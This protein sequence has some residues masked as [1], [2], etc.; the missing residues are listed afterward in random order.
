MALTTL[1]LV[2]HGATA[3]NVRE[4]QCLQGRWQDSE[5]IEAGH[6]QAQ[7]TGA[8][9]RGLSLSAIYSSPLMRA[10]QTAEHI[11]VG[12][13]KPVRIV[14]TLIEADVGQW[15]DL[16]WAAI[17]KRWPAE[18]QAFH[19]DAERHGY[20]GGENMAQVRD[21][22]LPAIERLIER[23]AG[24]TFVVVGHGVANRALLAHWMGLPLRY[25]RRVPQDNGAFSVIEVIEG[26]VRL[27]T[28][29]YSP[30]PGAHFALV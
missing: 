25:T 1:I 16:S 22:V 10:R 30:L 24:E 21:R 4:P 19:E 26:R 8:A 11:A 7:A 15:Q 18:C 17:E 13:G 20:L 14:D 27:R 5:L 6:A 2:R 3:V 12:R 29:N 9:L 23:H 28:L